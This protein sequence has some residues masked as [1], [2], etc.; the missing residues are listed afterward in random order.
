M[1]ASPR[2]FLFNPVGSHGDVHPFLGIAKAMQERGHD[3]SVLTAE[4]FRDVAEKA[5]L[6]FASHLED[7]VFQ[8]LLEDPD[9]WHP[10]KGAGILLRSMAEH[11]RQA[12]E[13]LSEAYEPGR[14][15]IVAASLAFGARI[16]QD[17]HNAPVVSMHLAPSAFRTMHLQPAAIPGKDASG[18][19]V[20]L[21][22]LMWWAI[23][24]LLLDRHIEPTVNAFRTEL[25]LPTISRPF[26]DWLHSPDLTI[27]LFPKWFAPAQPDWPEQVRL[28]GFPLFD[29]VGQHQLDPGL[30]RFLGKGTPP[31]AFTPGSAHR[32]AAEFFSAAI[33]ATDKLGRTCL[34]FTRHGDQI[35]RDLP[36]HA[37]HEAFVPF[38]TVLPRCAAIVHHGGVGTCAQG[39]AAGIP[40]LIMPMG[41]DQPDNV[42]R[43]QRLGVASWVVPQRFTGDRVAGAL[44]ELLTSEKV[45]ESCRRW[46]EELATTD[47]VRE[48]CELIEA[49]GSR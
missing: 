48:T 1:H 32:H 43:L 24:R 29:E 7:T 35:P 4:T 46:K 23:D 45:A 15:V 12:Y 13:C 9:L 44:N 27:G 3:V 10:R 42:T 49:V 21:K 17:K 30:E 6:R 20:P 25:G 18:W 14:T 47:P 40:Q 26:K 31:I 28:T 39:L 5:G 8:E 22:Q 34:L 41:F 33:D 38:S 16:F 2:H 19:P 36:D 11:L 37:R